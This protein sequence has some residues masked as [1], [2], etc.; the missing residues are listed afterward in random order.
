MFLYTSIDTPSCKCLTKSFDWTG[1]FLYL[2]ASICSNNEVSSFLVVELNNALIHSI[3]LLNQ[4]LTE[5]STLVD[6]GFI[7]NLSNWSASHLHN[8]FFSRSLVE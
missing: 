1:V 4:D 2:P 8:I 5:D 6:L 7:L 3:I